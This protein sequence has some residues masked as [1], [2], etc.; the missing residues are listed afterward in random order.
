ML[1]ITLICVGKLKE[2]HYIAACEEYQKRLS[3]FYK[4]SVLEL[5]EERLPENPSPAQITAALAAEGKRIAAKIP[6]NAAVAALCV[7][8][9]EMSSPD[10]AAAIDKLAVSGASHIVFLIGGSFGLA[11]KAKRL[12][13]WRLSLSPMTFPHHLARVLLLEQLY[14]AGQISG[15]GK[16]HK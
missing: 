10:F 12:A 1:S 7:E 6:S 16:Y 13:K 3:A 2:P 11:E 15:G 5:P 14:R 8:G 9:E 4:L